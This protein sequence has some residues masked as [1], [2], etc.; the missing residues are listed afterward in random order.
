[1]KTTIKGDF[2]G[3]KIVLDCAHGSAYELAPKVFRELGAEIITVGA[4]PD[5]R[6]IN[7]G[8]G[9]THPEYLRE[10][11]L[12]HGAD[13]GLSFDGDADRLIAIDD[14]GEEVDGDYILCICGDAMKRAGKL[15]NDT[16]VT[17]VMANIGFFKATRRSACKRLRRLLETVT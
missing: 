17:T 15:K 2:K 10:Q 1:M 12:A 8:V 7:A 3:L 4:E 11:V 6:N 13:L 16:V 5:G 14:K 9:S